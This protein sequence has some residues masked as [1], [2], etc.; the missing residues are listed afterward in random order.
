MEFL[1]DRQFVFQFA[2]RTKCNLDIMD[3]AL[4]EGKEVYE[5]TQLVSSLMGLIVFPKERSVTIKDLTI[6]KAILNICRPNTQI[7]TGKKQLSLNEYIKYMR[8]ALSHC[9]V[10]FPSTTRQGKRI[11]E[12]VV[13]I[14]CDHVNDVSPCK[15]GRKSRTCLQCRY[16][17]KSPE[18]PD[19]VLAL[20]VQD[21][22]KV[23]DLIVEDFVKQAEAE[24]KEKSKNTAS[25]PK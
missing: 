12:K 18:K 14:N 6:Q 22:R 25:Q 9:H 11:I 3:N 7:K 21:M 15:S 10:F 1:K 5:V 8:H 4:K 20:T 19:F 2:K 23:V 24:E 17:N 13:F 16:K